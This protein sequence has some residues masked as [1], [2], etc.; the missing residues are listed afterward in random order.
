MR[1]GDGRDFPGALNRARRIEVAP[2]LAGFGR[3]GALVSLR[4][5]R[6]PGPADTVRGSFD[7]HP[8]TQNIVGKQVSEVKKLS[9]R[10]SITTHG[11]NRHTAIESGVPDS[12]ANWKSARLP[13]ITEA[14]RSASSSQAATRM[15]PRPPPRL[16]PAPAA[17]AAG[18]STRSR[19]SRGWSPPPSRSA[20][21]RARARDNNRTQTLLVHAHPRFVAARLCFG[22]LPPTPTWRCRACTWSWLV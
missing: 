4:R 16:P 7:Q 20:S 17:A 11:Q 13:H 9:L 8:L 1:W 18:G 15:K 19:R 10:L 5:A 6:A 14:I 22:L 3:G 2:P 12:T 21:S